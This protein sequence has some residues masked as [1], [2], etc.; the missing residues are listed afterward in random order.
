MDGAGQ[1]VA[2]A[3]Q[4]EYGAALGAGDFLQGSGIQPGVPPPDVPAQ[5]PPLLLLPA[6]KFRVLQGQGRPLV[7]RRKEGRRALPQQLPAG[8]FVH[9]GG[10]AGLG[11]VGQAEPLVFKAVGQTVGDG[12]VIV[13]DVPDP[14]GPDVALPA[15][16]GLN[17]RGKLPVGVGFSWKGARVSTKLMFRPW[18]WGETWQGSTRPASSRISTWAKVGL[19][20]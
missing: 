15:V 8:A 10:D 14:L 13:D 6:G 12:V 11:A 2:Q 7:N 17:R 4:G 20:M 18:G 5:K 1:A 9:K 3:E 16:E 19:S